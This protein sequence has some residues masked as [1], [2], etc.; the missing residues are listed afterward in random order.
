MVGIGHPVFGLPR[1]VVRVKERA[2]IEMSAS[3]DVRLGERKKG[4][5]ATGRQTIEEEG[6]A[7]EKEDPWRS[8]LS[9]FTTHAGDPER[10]Q[11]SRNRLQ[12][13]DA[14]LR[15]TSEPVLICI[16]TGR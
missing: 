16:R 14:H 13:L 9:G 8:I 1:I 4:L 3:H 2:Q 6:E 10:I 12:A 11:R 7:T 15:Q 5:L